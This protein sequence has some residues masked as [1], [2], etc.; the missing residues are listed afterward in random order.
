MT[1]AR[2]RQSCFRTLPMVSSTAS[3]SMPPFPTNDGGALDRLYRQILADPDDIGLRL[4]YADAAAGGYPD[5]AELVRLE[6]EH[7]EHRRA[8]TRLEPARNERMYRLQRE[9]GLRPR[10]DPN[11]AERRYVRRGFP[12]AVALPAAAFLERAELLYAQAPIRAVYLT[13]GA[14][15]HIDALA[16]SPALDRLTGLS[17]WGARN[18]VD[19]DA[20]RVLA[21]SPHLARLRW[22]N[23][24]QTGVTEAGI[25]ALAASD[26]LPN[27]RY[28][29]VDSD[30]RLNPV[31]GYDYDG[32]LVDV[33][34]PILGPRLAERYDRPWL[35]WESTFAREFEWYPEYDEV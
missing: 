5:Y 1:N 10:P 23:L 3:H 6:V 8:G 35:H 15:E 25:E 7:G 17:L 13:S 29:G 31:P 12:E 4:R 24:E 27:L 16:A 20:V 21:G 33:T 19:D 26:R 34:P 30:L 28:V 32:S 2:N 22:L 9:L 18:R 14:G 11:L